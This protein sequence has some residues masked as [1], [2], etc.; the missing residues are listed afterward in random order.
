M[1]L[2][3]RLTIVLQTV[4]LT[5]YLFSCDSRS[6]SSADMATAEAAPAGMEMDM[7]AE[8]EGSDDAYKASGADEDQTDEPTQ[9][10]TAPD[11]I[12]PRQVIKTGQVEMQV[13]DIGASNQAVERLVSRYNGY[14]SQ[15]ETTS[16]N[17]QLGSNLVLRIPAE[18]FDTILGQ[19]VTQGVHITRKSISAQDVTQEYV[20]IQIR[21]QTK[22][23]VR[24]RYVDILRNQAKTVKD[25]LLAEEQIRG[26]QEEIEAAEGRLRYLK[27]QTSLATI[28]LNMYQVIEYVPTPPS[29]RN[30]FW[31]RVGR[32]LANGWSGIGE[33][34][35]VLVNIWPLVL[36]VVLFLIWKR[37]WFRK[38]L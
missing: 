37:R 21:L 27:N 12:I 4:L 38:L 24:D 6:E 1:I 15:S 5:F 30:N 23:E 18:Q 20:D 28:Y 32:G 25:V 13:D 14:I 7:S 34:L 11:E 36:V 17:Y 9:Q 26:L 2:T 10:A 31:R 19:V 33:F 3:M 35:V 22:K 16:S 8:N 29:V